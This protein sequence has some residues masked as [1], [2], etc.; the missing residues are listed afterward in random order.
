MDRPDEPGRVR[1][2]TSLMVRA[3]AASAY[4]VYSDYR[5]WPLTFPTI[6]GA[7]LLRADGHRLVLEVDHVEGRVIN[8]LTLE[9]QREVRLWEVKRRYDALFVNRFEPM[10]NGARITV[11]A[12]IRPKG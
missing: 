8:E 4:E 11:L 12:D 6:F 10:P 2:Q 3:T 1:I 7:R 9:P 5:R